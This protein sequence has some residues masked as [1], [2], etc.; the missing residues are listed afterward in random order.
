M[1]TVIYWLAEGKNAVRMF[2]YKGMI[3]LTFFII[4]SCSDVSL[5]EYISKNQEEREIIALLIQ[6]Q[7]AKN[8]SDI[9][10]F[11]SLLHEQGRYSFFDLKVSKDALKK[12][13]PES[14][15]KLESG[16]ALNDLINHEGITGD[17]F[18]T[19]CLYNPKI[20]LSKNTAIVTVMVKFNWWWGLRHHI[21]LLRDNNGRWVINCLNWQTV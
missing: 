14:W 3:F 15:A 6:Y 2:K 11:L 8:R 16:E 1:A 7:E 9:E 19:W 10:Q 17:Y 21:R 4:T 13:L 5:K 20:K 18:R 12:M